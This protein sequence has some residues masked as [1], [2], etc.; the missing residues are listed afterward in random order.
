MLDMLYA[1]RESCPLDQDI[2]GDVESLRTVFSKSAASAEV[3][4]RRLIAM[5]GSFSS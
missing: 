4:K 1:W 3:R 2:T 5:L